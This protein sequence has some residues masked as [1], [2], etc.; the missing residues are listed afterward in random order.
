MRVLVTGGTGFVGSWIVRFLL[1]RGHAVR[2][3]TRSSSRFTNLEGLDLE[4]AEGDVTDRESVRR[5]VAGCDGVVHTAGIAHFRPG[6][7]ERLLAVN[8]EGVRVVL[9]E[10]L[11]AGVRRAVATSSIGA[12]GGVDH[13]RVADEGTPSNAEET[14]VDYLISKYRGERA[15]LAVADRGLSLSVLRPGYVLGPGDIYR[16]S[17][18]TIL[19]MARGKLPAFVEGGA[20][21]CDVRDVAAAH[22]E[23]LERGGAGQVYIAA[24]HNLRLSELGAKVSALS[25]VPA[26]RKV[27]YPV[28]WTA[29][30][31]AEIAGRLTGRAPDISRQLVAAGALFT[32]VSSE[33][34]S[35]ELGY[36]IRPI[37]DSLRDTLRF[38]LANGRLRPTTPELRALAEN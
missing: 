36:R 15:A 21:F 33:K 31:A 19:A 4:R 3:L 7:F 23:A 20:S 29:A 27:P 24:G 8:V 6:Q 9:E 10:A 28:A 35:R 1:E 30:L 32:F 18:T 13:P 14:G 5:A 37:E 17:A 2:L 16:S 22:V 12:I 11:A 38:F 26:P 34:A 25:G